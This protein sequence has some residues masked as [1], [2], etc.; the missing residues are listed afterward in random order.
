[1]ILVHNKFISY[2]VFYDETICD[3]E[4]DVLYVL[5]VSYRVSTL[6]WPRL[7]TCSI[8]LY[9]VLINVLCAA[10]FINV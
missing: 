7:S 3:D 2:L 1:M 5:R 6:E 9:K 8:F 4:T 10:G